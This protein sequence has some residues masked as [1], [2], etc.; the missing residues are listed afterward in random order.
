MGKWSEWYLGDQEHTESRSVGSDGQP[1]YN[2]ERFLK[3]YETLR[4]IS[5]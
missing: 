4:T 3:L 5:A 2:F 1:S